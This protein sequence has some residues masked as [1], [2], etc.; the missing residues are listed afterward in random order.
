MTI[1]ETAALMTSAIEAKYGRR[2]SEQ[3]ISLLLED[4]YGITN[5]NREDQWLN[6]EEIQPLIDRILQ[7]EPIQYITG[8]AHFY[9]HKFE[10]NK[11]VLIPRPE[12]EELVYRVLRDL[13]GSHRQ[14]DVMDIGAGSG[15]IGITLKKEQPSLRVF[16]VE[17]SKDALNVARINARK[18]KAQLIFYLFDFLDERVWDQMG[19]F[20]IIVSN[21]PY[22]AE[23]ERSIMADNVLLYEPEKA[24]FAGEDPLVFYKAIARFGDVHL[25]QDGK[26]YLELNPFYTV[27][28]QEIFADRGWQA[29][30]ESDLQGKDRILVA[31]RQN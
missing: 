8:V 2:E 12:T 7:G 20:D 16:E 19:R 17:H 22:I 11:H 24:L 4:K 21:P 30:V 6:D 14:Y 18:L 26:I 15:C 10:V 28:I 1:A 25:H 9:G 29:E 23:Y 5:I 13:K 27:E 3:M 31:S